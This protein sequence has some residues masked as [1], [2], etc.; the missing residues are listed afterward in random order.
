MLAKL[1]AA[2]PSGKVTVKMTFCPKTNRRRDLDNLI[3]ATKSLRDGI[4]DAIGIDDSKTEIAAV[5]GPIAPQRA[6]VAV[7]ISAE[8]KGES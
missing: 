8:L 3:A 5:I 2:N 1:V 7:D 6:F 4:S